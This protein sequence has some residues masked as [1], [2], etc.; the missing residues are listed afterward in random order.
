M[1]ISA[2]PYSVEFDG[3][4]GDDPYVK[5]WRAVLARNIEDALGN[6]SAMRSAAYG[7]RDALVWHAAG[8]I[9]S[10]DFRE[11]AELAGFDPDA[12]L[13]RL[14]PVMAMPEKERL[15][16]LRKMKRQMKEAGPRPFY[17]YDVECREPG[18]EAMV[19]RVSRSGYCPEHIHQP[20]KCECKLCAFRARRKAKAAAKRAKVVA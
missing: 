20:G 16:W 8:W 4:E 19:S 7:T 18:C 13:D 17:G 14:K 6:P 12:L 3:A 11:V 15:A 10:R 9:G 1:T 2:L 5:L